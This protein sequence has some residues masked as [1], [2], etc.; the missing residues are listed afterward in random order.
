MPRPGAS[1]MVDP[2]HR[3]E[4]ADLNR[5][6]LQSQLLAAHSSR[7]LSILQQQIQE[8]VESLKQSISSGSVAPVM[9]LHSISPQAIAPAPPVAMVMQQPVQVVQV[10]VAM[11]N[12]QPAG[13]QIRRIDGGIVYEQNSLLTPLASTETGNDAAAATALLPAV[14]ASSS[15][16]PSSAPASAAQ[17]PSASSSSSA[18]TSTTV[19]VESPAL[20][21]ANAAS[22]FGQSEGVTGAPSAAVLGSSASMQ[23]MAIALNSMVG[24]PAELAGGGEAAV[25]T[26][27]GATFGTN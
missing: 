1:L 24:V 16:T 17:A 18:S 7:Q 26:F 10:P 19:H 5:L 8:K 23:P 2:R 12:P 14:V 21:E 6:H 3:Q 22:S 11:L 13:L 4:L 9:G 15:G 25:E 27:S 20:I